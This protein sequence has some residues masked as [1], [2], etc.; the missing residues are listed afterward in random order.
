MSPR[1]NVIAFPTTASVPTS[2]PDP[3]AIE[4]GKLWRRIRLLGSLQ[5]YIEIGRKLRDKL[6]QLKRGQRLK[7]VKANADVMGFGDRTA[8]WMGAKKLET[9]DRMGI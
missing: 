5:G 6:A 9:E 8:R 1:D 4:I 2:A 3:D 7:W